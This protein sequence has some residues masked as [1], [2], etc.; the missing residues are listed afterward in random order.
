M[1]A[2][3]DPYSVLEVG[4]S[5]THDE[6]RTSYKK[7]ARKY[8]PDANV[9][10]PSALEKF[11]QVQVAWDILGDKEKRQNFD[12]YGS[13]DGPH[14][15]SGPAAEGP[16]AGQTW[17]WS[18]ADGG[19]VPFDIEELFGGRSPFGGSGSGTRRGSRGARRGDWPVRGQDVRTEIEVPFTVAAEGGMYDLHLQRSSGGGPETLSVK[20]PAGIDTGTVIRLA[21]QGEPGINGGTAGDLLVAVR[22]A[23]HPYFRRE[24]SNLLLDVPVGIVEATLGA[25][26][27]IPTLS[28]GTV[29]MSV[30][31]GSSSG[32]KLRLKGK[33]IVN[34]ATTQRGDQLAVLK[35]VA[36]KE[37]NDRTR[38][39]LN[40]L[41]RVAPQNVRD[42]LWQA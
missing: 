17:T 37:L 38:E 7:L 12:K 34:R 6:I 8:H 27:E 21:G 40:E 15:R 28:E 20:V 29:L 42:G 41:K 26:V 1:S 35:I 33:G 31:P 14:V 25:K 5:A 32:T 24:G 9:D 3:F 2:E 11:K 10:D 23:K 22:V 18:S 30:P 36:P 16:G 13:P 19:E 39:L 4:R